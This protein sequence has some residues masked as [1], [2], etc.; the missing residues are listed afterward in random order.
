MKYLSISG[1]A[2]KHGIIREDLFNYFEYKKLIK[3]ENKHWILTVK[4]Q[5]ADGK[6]KENKDGGKWT[7]WRYDFSIN[8]FNSVKS[9][10]DALINAAASAASDA[11]TQVKIKD[12][13]I[14]IICF[15][16]SHKEGGRCIA[17]FLYNPTTSKFLVY[18]NSKK[19]IWIRPICNTEHEEVPNNIAKEI[20][21][22]DIIEFKSDLKY[23]R[24]DY[25]NENKLIQNNELKIIENKGIS[26]SLLEHLSQNNNYPYIFDDS[27]S[28]IGNDKIRKLKPYY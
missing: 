18:K 24:T 4:G 6:L 27:K 11:P 14:S 15:S 28:S 19:T 25:Q 12:A 20:K 2:R 23:S 3:K 21:I 7:I 5:E 16:N 26:K 9:K 13:K 8:D 10:I 22:G 1:L 17:G